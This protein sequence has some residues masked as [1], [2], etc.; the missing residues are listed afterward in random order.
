EWEAPAALRRR[1]GPRRGGWS[2][3]VTHPGDARRAGLGTI[4]KGV[5]GYAR[6]DGGW[7]GRRG[8][9]AATTACGAEPGDQPRNCCAIFTDFERG[10]RYAGNMC[11][12]GDGPQVSPADAALAEIERGIDGLRGCASAGLPKGS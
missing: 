11:S 7:A 9:A 1:E 5:A 10:V 12:C 8:L 6:G 4:S 3:G 2:A